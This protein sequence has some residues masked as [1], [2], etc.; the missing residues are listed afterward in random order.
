MLDLIKPK[1]FIPIHGEYRHLVHHSDVAVESGVADDH[2]IVAVNGDII[3]LTKDSCKVIEHMDEPRVLI[4]G[5]EGN[6]VSKLVLKERRQIGETGIVFALMVRN[7]ETMQI[8]SGPEIIAKGFMNE[9]TEGWLIEESR[10]LVKKI[11]TN[12][13]AAVANRGPESDLQET[14]RIEL[15]RFF[16]ANVGKKPVVLPMIIDL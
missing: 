7:Q 2:V 13:E 3:E 5:R 12:H 16:N 1:F 6:D 4:E 10:K 14:I 8:I 11:I 9:A 15:R